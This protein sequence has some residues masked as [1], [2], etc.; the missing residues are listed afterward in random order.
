MHFYTPDEGDLVNSH[1]RY[2]EHGSIISGWTGDL[3]GRL[4]IEPVRRR[5]E[6]AGVPGPRA[7][8]RRSKIIV[9][10]EATA[11]VDPRRDQMIRIHGTSST[12]PKIT[13]GK[14]RRS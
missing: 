2:L 5:G 7:V 3:P 11:N 14:R 4:R 10:D 6:P 9:M 8:P 1:E 13:F 12:V